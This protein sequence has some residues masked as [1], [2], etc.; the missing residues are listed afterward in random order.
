MRLDNAQIIGA[1]ALLRWKSASATNTGVLY[2]HD[3]MPLLEKSGLSVKVGEWVIYEGCRQA[4]EWNRMFP[5]RPAMFITCNVGARQL[6]SATFR[7]RVVDSIASTGVQPWQLCLDITEAALRFGLN[8]AEAD[9]VASLVRLHLV[10]AETATTADL[11]DEDSVL[12]VAARSFYARRD[13][14]RGLV[15]MQGSFRAWSL[16]NVTSVR[17][18]PSSL[19]VRPIPAAFFRSLTYFSRAVFF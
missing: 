16:K 6:A 1:E 19:R 7:D 2:P 4:A 11:D 10:P 3:F 12:E 18:T 5:T 15:T 8:A 17:S 13:A 14:L 9:E